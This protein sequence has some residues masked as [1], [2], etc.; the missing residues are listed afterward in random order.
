MILLNKEYSIERGI[1]PYFL[2]GLFIL[3]F[4]FMPAIALA[5]DLGVLG[6]TYPIIEEDFLEFIQNRIVQMKSNGQWETVKQHIQQEVK[7]HTDRPNPVKNISKTIEARTWVYDPSV[8]VPNDMRDQN[9]QVFI[10]AGT[11]MNPLKMMSLHKAWV[12][13]DGDDVDQVV[14]VKQIDKEYQ[15]KIKLILVK[16][17]VT[18]QQ[19]IFRQPIYFD[20]QGRLTTKFTIQH[21]PALIAQEGLYLRISERVP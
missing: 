8:M 5:K 3:I 1:L 13:Y 7:A 9:G 21:V 11:M 17:S 19:K 6:Q 14:W 18:E 12:F 10:K 4:H 2:Y 20:Q 15:G 16:G